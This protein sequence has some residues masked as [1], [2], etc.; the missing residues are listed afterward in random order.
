MSN[1]PRLPGLDQ[2]LAVMREGYEFLPRRFARLG[3]DVLEARLLLQKTICLR[4]SEAAAVFYD[5]SRFRRRGATPRRTRRTLLGRGGVQGL[6]GAAHFERKA[7]FMRLMHPPA[8]ERMVQLFESHWRDAVADWQQRGRIE[9]LAESRKV[10][11]RAVCEWAAVPL[12]EADVERR[13]A[14]LSALIDGAARVGPR[15]WRARL[16]RVQTNC[17]IAG[18]IQRIRSGLLHAPP[19]SAAYEIAWQRERGRLLSLRVAAVELINVLRPTLA[20]ARFIT[21]AGLALHEHRDRLAAIDPVW[22]WN[23]T[24]DLQ[25]FVQEVRRFYPFFPFVAA[26]VRTTFQWRGYRFP[27]NRRV[28]L[29]IYGSNRHPGDWAQPEEFRPERFRERALDPFTLIPQGGGDHHFGH[30][31]AGEWI[32]IAV[33]VAAVRNL[34]TQMR[35]WVPEQDLRVDLG[36]IPTQPADG[37]LIEVGE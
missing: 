4:G 9:L 13:S 27:R 30:R 10:L 21:F 15:H 18:V 34:T 17:W 24:E 23:D 2:T 28:L 25:A 22:D 19:G 6:D 14:Q 11:L 35:Y 20:I 5:A 37:F 12:P 32:T 26:R 31:C 1:I 29:D 33:M 8:I 7:M 36:Q 16:A 3:T